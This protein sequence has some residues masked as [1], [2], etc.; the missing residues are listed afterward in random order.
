MSLNVAEFMTFAQCTAFSSL[1]SVS[2]RVESI[3]ESDAD[4][5][6]DEDDTRPINP[7]AGSMTSQPLTG[8]TIQ[9]N[10]TPAH[11]SSQPSTAGNLRYNRL[12]W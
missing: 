10:E 5:D 8:G 3:G 9:Q 2:Y 7:K 1:G 12:A 6:G 4:S 11:S